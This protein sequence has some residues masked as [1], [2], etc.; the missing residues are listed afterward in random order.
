MRSSGEGELL[1][2]EEE[3]EEEEE[4]EAEA[5]REG[6]LGTTCCM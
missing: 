4:A 2:E 1:G 5:G 3:E 6:V